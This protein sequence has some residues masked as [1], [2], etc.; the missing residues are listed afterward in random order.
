MG[1]VLIRNEDMVAGDAVAS[2]MSSGGN[3]WRR[4]IVGT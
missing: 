3:S 2:G 4:A 1:A